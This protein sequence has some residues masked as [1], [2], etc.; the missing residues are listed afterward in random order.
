MTKEAD[1]R[2]WNIAET[3]VRFELEKRGWTVYRASGEEQV[4]IDMI[5]VKWIN[6]NKLIL[7]AIQVKSRKGFGTKY[8]TVMW[9]RI[10]KD[11]KLFYIAALPLPSGKWT[12]YIVPTDEVQT[13]GLNIKKDGMYEKYRDKWK[14]LESF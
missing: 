2:L 11:K 14:T 3:L 8:P 9:S 12:F 4:R 1:R 5:A 10:D 13:I 7:R 6:E